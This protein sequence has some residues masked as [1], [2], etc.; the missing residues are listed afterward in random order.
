MKKRGPHL[1]VL[2][3]TIPI[4]LLT[5]CGCTTDQ[6]QAHSP[7]S[8]YFEREK[9]KFVGAYLDGDVKAHGQRQIRRAL[10]KKNILEA[11]EGFAGLS[12]INPK[13]VTIRRGQ[14]SYK[15][16]FIEMERG[17]WKH[18]LINEGDTIIVHRIIF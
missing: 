17:K 15:I 13:S 18:F 14:E 5:F 7:E 3:K 4:I 8:E 1:G 16:Q 9:D 11:A 2:I 10:S 12:M 6:H